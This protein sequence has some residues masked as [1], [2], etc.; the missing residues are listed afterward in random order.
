MQSDSNAEVIVGS[1]GPT[2][3]ELETETTGVAE[4]SQFKVIL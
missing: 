4:T 1:D 3:T 2:K